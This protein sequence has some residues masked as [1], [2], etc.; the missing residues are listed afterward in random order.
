[1]ALPH[2]L[3]LSQQVH[4]TVI[5][6]YGNGTQDVFTETFH[7][8]TLSSNILR[9]GINEGTQL[10]LY[11][12]PLGKILLA[13]MNDGE[14]QE[15]LNKNVLKNFTPNTITN[16]NLLKNHLLKVRQE[17]IAFDEEE[18]EIGLSGIG[19]GIQDAEGKIQGAI[20]VIGPSARLT[21]ARIQELIPEVKSYALRISRELGFTQ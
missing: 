6:A 4:E 3:K 16:P 13:D 18:H 9:I 2:L 5:I 10:P 8:S 15:Y 1:L 17:G 7:D 11:T 19:A 14:L 20:A 21:R 12:N